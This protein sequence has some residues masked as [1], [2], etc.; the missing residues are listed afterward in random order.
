MTYAPRKARSAGGAAISGGRL[1]SQIS[2]LML[3]IAVIAVCAGVWHAGRVQGIALAVV[4]LPALCY[5][6]FA[7]FE[8]AAAGRPMDVFDK[9]GSFALALA[10]AGLVGLAAFIAFWITC[11]PAV[12]ASRNYGIGIMIGGMVGIAAAAYVISRI[13]RR[14]RAAPW[15]R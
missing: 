6:T 3:L 13:V 4:A 1:A 12:I 5:T 11:I 7:A 14:S 2:S 9:L 10:G 15:K 8:S